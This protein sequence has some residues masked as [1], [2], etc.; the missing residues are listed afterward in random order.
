MKK[1]LS[2]IAISL[3]ALTTLATTAAYTTY[4]YIPKTGTVATDSESEVMAAF[5]Y[6]NQ[7]RQNPAAY[8]Q[9][10]GVDLSDVQPRPELKWNDI[11]AQVATQRAQDMVNRNYFAHVDPDGYGTNIKLQNAGYTLN[12][13][14]YAKP[15]DNFFE[16][17]AAGHA[18]GKSSVIQLINDGGG[19]HEQSGHR[20]HL[21]G[22]KEF[23]AN[24]DE[25]GIGRAEGGRYG[26]VWCFIIAKH[27][28]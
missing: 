27:D 10:I 20:L 19:T 8:S 23:W 12:P 24:C 3:L 16:S 1:T 6:L 17:L 26:T 14:F 21:L 22:I 7:V 25:I 4:K 5:R 11:L 9:E 28:F 15:S 13:K 18:D 2:T